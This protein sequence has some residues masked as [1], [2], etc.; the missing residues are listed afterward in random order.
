VYQKPFFNNSL[1]TR[2][3]AIL[4][5]NCYSLQKTIGRMTAQK[6]TPNQAKKYSE[7]LVLGETSYRSLA[8]V[9]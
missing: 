8:I 7:N 2:K 3:G 1:R 5:V 9:H 4:L 6:K